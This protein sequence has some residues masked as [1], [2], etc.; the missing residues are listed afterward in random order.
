MDPLQLILVTG[1][2]GAFFWVLKWIVDGKLHTHS[3]VQ[4]LRA[5]KAELSATVKTLTEAVTAGNKTME[6]ILAILTSGDSE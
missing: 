3:E 1:A 2:A 5:D 4:G 6:E